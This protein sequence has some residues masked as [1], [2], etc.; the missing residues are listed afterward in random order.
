[1]NPL[2]ATIKAQQDLYIAGGESMKE[3]IKMILDYYD[4]GKLN[5]KEVINQIKKLCEIQK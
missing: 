3:R 5:E 1:M 2:E 4:A